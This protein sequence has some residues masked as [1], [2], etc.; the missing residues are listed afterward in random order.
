M[1]CECETQP[2]EEWHLDDHDFW[3]YKLEVLVRCHSGKCSLLDEFMAIRITGRPEGL[4]RGSL[5]GVR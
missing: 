2:K 5:R 1:K 3:G 4:K